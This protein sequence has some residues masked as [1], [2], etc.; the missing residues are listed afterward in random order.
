M[1]YKEFRA[2]DVKR[3]SK[4]FLH[5]VR[6]FFLSYVTTWNNN[7]S[8]KSSVI[9]PFKKMQLIYGRT[10]SRLLFLFTRVCCHFSCRFLK[11]GGTRELSL[12]LLSSNVTCIKK[13]DGKN[14]KKQFNMKNWEILCKHLN[15]IWRRIFCNQYFIIHVKR[16]DN[17][18]DALAYQFVNYCCIYY[19]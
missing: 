17:L 9:P 2:Q 18:I 5:E 1:M 15:K 4:K 10:F 6:H 16:E 14:L 13:W 12:L 11:S 7:I 3:I 8:H 19:I